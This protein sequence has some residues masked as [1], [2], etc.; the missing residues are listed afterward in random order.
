MQY[1]AFGNMLCKH[2]ASREEK[3]LIMSSLFYFIVACDL[4]Y[5]LKWQHF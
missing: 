3:N 5:S 1:F 4:W 2:N